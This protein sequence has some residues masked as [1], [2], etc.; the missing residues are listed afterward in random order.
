MLVRITVHHPA[1]G[2]Y[3]NY[4]NSDIPSPR[5]QCNKEGAKHNSVVQKKMIILFVCFR[6]LTVS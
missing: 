5:I 4:S 3:F 2:H 6:V 1:L